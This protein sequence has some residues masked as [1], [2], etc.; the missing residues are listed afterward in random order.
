M[1]AANVRGPWLICHHL[2]P[3]LAD[4]AS[5]VLTGSNIGIRSSSP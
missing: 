4:G 3:R 2:G 5:V 1:L